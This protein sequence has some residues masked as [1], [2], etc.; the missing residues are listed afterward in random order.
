MFL[1]RLADASAAL[2]TV[3][4]HAGSRLEGFAVCHFGPD[5]GA[6]SGTCYVKFG[7]CRPGPQAPASFLRRRDACERLAGERRIEW[8]VAGAN[9]ARCP[10]CGAM[11]E[12]AFRPRIFGVARHR[13]DDPGYNRDDVLTID[14]WR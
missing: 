4:L 2:A 12:R 11:L 9:C 14:D 6:G 1:H 13:D 3:L 10:A 8:L 7:L 5:S